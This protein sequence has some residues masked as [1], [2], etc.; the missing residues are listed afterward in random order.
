MKRITT[1]ITVV[2][3]V[4]CALFAFCLTAQAASNE[5][6]VYSNDFS[7]SSAGWYQF[8]TNSGSLSVENG[9]LKMSNHTE[10]WH[11]P[12][13]DIYSLMQ[14]YGAGTYWVQISAKYTG[15]A[16]DTA[17]AYMSIRG[18]GPNSFLSNYSGNYLTSI[19]SHI[20]LQENVWTTFYGSIKILESDFNTAGYSTTM[21]LCLDGIPY[22]SDVQLFIDDVKIY[23]MDDTC[24]TNGSFNSGLVGWRPWCNTGEDEIGAEMLSSYNMFYG[25]YMRVEQYGSIA[26]NVDQILANYGVGR[27]VVSFKLWG[28]YLDDEDCG[29]FAVYFSKGTSA[30]HYKIG[31]F[32][33]NETVNDCITFDFYIGSELYNNLSPSTEEVFFRF[34]YL[35]DVYAPILY[36]IDDVFLVHQSQFPLSGG[37]LAYNEHIWAG[38]PMDYNNCYAYALNNQVYEGLNKL[39]DFQ[40][41]GAYYNRFNGTS[42]RFSINGFE[43]NPSLIVEAVKKDFELYNRLNSTNLIFMPIGRFEECPEGSYKVA[44]VVDPTFPDYHWYRQDSDGLWSHKQG[45]YPISRKDRSGSLIVDPFVADRG[46]YTVFVGYFAVSPWNNLYNPESNYN[47]KSLVPN[48]LNIELDDINCIT[49]GMTLQEVEN[50]L[51][52]NKVNIG[53]GSIIHQYHLS[54]GQIATIVYDYHIDDNYYVRSIIIEGAGEI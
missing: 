53:S 49:E 39:W 31:E 54:T 6:L 42:D 13:Y 43:D 10:A 36:F 27:Y 46:N 21:V 52:N 50:I 35:G 17:G 23:R 18:N 44:L 45:A 2:A 26:C 12:A 1:C 3:V 48:I 47:V 16:S 15:T 34:Q 25:R 33:L 9:V 38:E 7:S 28:N 11:S 8:G 32:N 30:Y 14:S 51:G 41:P 19:S 5:T 40:Q 20:S 22:G 37:E 4:F 29:E 24:I